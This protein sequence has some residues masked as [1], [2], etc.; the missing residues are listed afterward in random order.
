MP[1][2][3]TGFGHHLRENLLN[4]PVQM[5]HNSK[6]FPT[7][8]AVAFK[9]S[10]SLLLS[11]LFSLLP[12]YLLSLYSFLKLWCWSLSLGLA[13]LEMCSTTSSVF[14]LECESYDISI[15]ICLSLLLFSCSMLIWLRIL[16]IYFTSVSPGCSKQLRNA[17]S[18]NK[19]RKGWPE[20]YGGYNHQKCPHGCKH[21]Y[22]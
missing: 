3:H 1:S 11:L 18:I 10:L 6:L 7:D 9:F 20:C 17:H 19:F 13:Y 5:N 8:A 4:P 14:L 21:K 16:A 22:F 15:L 2:T 12:S